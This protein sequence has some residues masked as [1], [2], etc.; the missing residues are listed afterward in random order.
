MKHSILTILIVIVICITI[1]VNAQQPTQDTIAQQAAVENKEKEIDLSKLTDAERKQ[2]IFETLN[3]GDTNKIKPL[4]KALM[5]YRHNEA[6][7]PR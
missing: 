4:L 5:Y 1:H 7:R 3:A 2:L 6:G